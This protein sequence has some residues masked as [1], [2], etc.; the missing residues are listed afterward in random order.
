MSANER[1]ALAYRIIA[2][3]PSVTDRPDGYRFLADVRDAMAAKGVTDRESQNDLL[4]A[5]VREGFGS[6]ESA[7]NLKALLER[8]HEAAFRLGG[9]DQHVVHIEHRQGVDV[10]HVRL[11]PRSGSG[12]AV[13]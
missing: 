3:V 8:D 9:A 11:T 2:S 12:R 5:L 6:T 10:P 1:A 7:S 4:R 13:L